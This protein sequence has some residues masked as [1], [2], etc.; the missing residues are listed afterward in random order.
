MKF[1]GPV[2]TTVKN[3]FTFK[4]ANGNVIADIFITEH[5]PIFQSVQTAIFNGP[6]EARSFI[7]NNFDNFE[8]G[9][10]FI[11]NFFKE[12]GNTYK[13]YLQILI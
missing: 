1:Y 6:T 9:V 3:Y 7:F 10:E 12:K 5:K 11:V 2:K 4:N 13:N 8:E